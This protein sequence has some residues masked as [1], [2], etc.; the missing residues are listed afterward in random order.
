[1]GALQLVV[2]VRRDRRTAERLTEPVVYAIGPALVLGLAVSV[3]HMND[4]TNTFNVFRNVGSS[5]LSREIVFGVAFAGLGFAF[6]LAQWL[7][8]GTFRLRQVLAAVTA[9]A[10]IALVWSMSQ[11]YYSLTTV[12]A[13]NTAVVPYHFLA[14]TVLLGALAVA[15]ALTVATVVRRRVAV[16]PAA[17]GTHGGQPAPPRADEGGRGSA[18]A[19]AVRVRVSE[20]NEPTTSTEWALT[21]R[22]VQVLAVVAAVVGVA[23]L[24]SY[25]LHVSALATDATGAAS[26]QVFSGAFFLARLV[27]LGLATVVLT[28]FTYRAASFAALERPHVL[29]VLITAAFAL[30]FVAELMGRSLHYDS[31]FRIGI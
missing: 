20:I 5:W 17:G 28:I 7:R 2:S 8:L 12:P 30:A 21:T 1:L 18:L 11:I 10:G 22:T 26:A 24:V 16:R 19:T 25:P 29:T 15:C 3:L 9:L 13:W 23:V 4:V 27:L 14:T 31:M 6:A